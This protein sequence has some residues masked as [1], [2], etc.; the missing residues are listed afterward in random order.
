MT[1][2]RSKKLRDIP[3]ILESFF[4]ST[5]ILLDFLIALMLNTGTTGPDLT[6][7]QLVRLYP[8]WSYLT[9]LLEG[10]HPGDGQVTV[11]KQDP[12]TFLHTFLYHAHSDR[13]L[14]LT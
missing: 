5:G 2:C 4:F 11:L 7:R 10:R 3:L 9:Y 12:G 1:Q 8:W 13:T 14:S 6:L